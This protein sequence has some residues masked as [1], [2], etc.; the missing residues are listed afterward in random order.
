MADRW[1]KILGTAS[2]TAR[3]V[4]NGFFAAVRLTEGKE[5]IDIGTLGCDPHDVMMKCIYNEASISSWAIVNPVVRVS[6]IMILEQ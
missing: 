6:P 5:W 3:V 1:A 4:Q 2:A